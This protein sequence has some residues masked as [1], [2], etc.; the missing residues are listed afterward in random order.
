MVGV[1]KFLSSFDG[2]FHDFN[3]FPGY[4][5][6][7]VNRGQES[8]PAF[9]R[10]KVPPAWPDGEPECQRHEHVICLPEYEERVEDR[11][12]H[13]PRQKP[14]G[15]V[16]GQEDDVDVQDEFV[17]ACAGYDRFFHDYSLT[18]FL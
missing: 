17:Y 2:L 5:D 15:E 4:R 12:S 14:P 16:N 7:Y 6:E 8:F 18:S 13:M 1:I 11:V 9:R 3:R 10:G